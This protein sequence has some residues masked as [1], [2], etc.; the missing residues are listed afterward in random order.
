M[1]RRFSLAAVFLMT[2]ALAPASLRAADAL[3][4]D[5]QPG[6]KVT[7]DGTSTVHD[8]KVE[9]RIVGGF[10]ELDP[11]FESDATLK[12]AKTPAKVEVT[13]TV[14]S[15]KSGKKLMDSVMHDAMKAAAHPNIV[16]KLQSM[17]PKGTASASG[18]IEFDTQGTLAVAG[19]T[20]TNS[21]AVKMEK[22]EA[23][24][25]KFTGT[26]S[27]KMTDFGI[28]PPSPTGTFGLIKTGDDVTINFEWLAA[29]AAAKP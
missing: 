10:I 24:K 20:K 7:I 19:V 9:S 25:L 27:V 12:S 15:L 8:W 6:S 11:S 22:I 3:R 4:F 29:K 2:F 1:I 14:R 17:T 13:I 23:G 16:Y 21:M 18:P 26:T 5:A 28:Q